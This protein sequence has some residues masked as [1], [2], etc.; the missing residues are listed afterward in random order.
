MQ[1]AIDR[2]RFTPLARLCGAVAVA[3]A[4]TACTSKQDPGQAQVDVRGTDPAGTA[5]APAP[6]PT[7]PPTLPSGAGIVS[8]DG[9]Q[10]ARAE[11]GDTVSTLA[12]RIGLSA[13]ELGAYN[14]LAATQPLRAG[15]E[16]VL[17]PRP[18]GYTA[19][20]APDPAVPAALPATSATVPDPYAADP[21]ATATTATGIEAQPLDPN[22]AAAQA[23]AADPAQLP[24]TPAP[25]AA[26]TAQAGGWS[27]DLVASAIDRAGATPGGGSD[28]VPPPSSADPL[29]ENPPRNPVLASPQLNQYQTP[30]PGSRP[31]Q[32]APAA[33]TPIASVV[34]STVPDAPQPATRAAETAPAA[35]IPALP[36]QTGAR[37]QRPVEGPIAVAY[38]AGQGDTRNDGVDFAAP[39]GAPV[40]A[41]E[42]GEVAL[43]SQA[44]GGLGTILLIRHR[45]ELLTVYG[46]LSDVLVAKGDR[47]GRGQRIGSVARPKPPAEPRMHFEIRRGAESI[48]PM[49]M[50]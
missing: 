31:A 3:A 50:L 18:G 30:Q 39:A 22:Q 8:Y 14:G 40:V 47:V 26:A 42:A 15:D 46:R 25:A 29:P 7:A 49:R 4:L 1:I 5:A 48:D 27:P 32:P 13:S 9:Y 21:Y 19:T 2:T 43:V 38:G 28:L 12:A 11:A 20:A 45:G 24:G 10:A 37:L 36:A 34:P 35:T 16:L 17:P 23:T 44:L 33:E 41:A 6:V